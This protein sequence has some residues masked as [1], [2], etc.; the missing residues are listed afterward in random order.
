MIWGAIVGGMDGERLTGWM[1][2]DGL[3]GSLEILQKGERG[4]CC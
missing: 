2:K 4:I 1:V 3:D